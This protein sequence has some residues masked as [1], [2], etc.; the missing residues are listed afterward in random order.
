MEDP[1]MGNQMVVEIFRGE[2]TGQVF[3][4]YAE[5]SEAEDGTSFVSIHGIDNDCNVLMVIFPTF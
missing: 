5:G 1:D 2:T 3:D 4:R